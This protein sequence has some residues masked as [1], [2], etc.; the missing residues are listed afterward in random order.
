MWLL[1]DW[2]PVQDVP[3]LLPLKYFLAIYCYVKSY[4]TSK[5]KNKKKK[6]VLHEKSLLS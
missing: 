2:L 4:G 6:Q 3:R 1:M 5:K